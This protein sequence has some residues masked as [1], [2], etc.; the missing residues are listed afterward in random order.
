MGEK[1]K[2]QVLEVYID[3]GCFFYIVAHLGYH[4]FRI[5]QF[6]CNQDG[7]EQQNE[8]DKYRGANAENY[9][10][11]SIHRLF[12]SSSYMKLHQKGTE[13]L[14]RQRSAKVASAGRQAR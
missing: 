3:T 12:L 9:F 7:G 5:D 6:R 10:S 13:H 1:I 2:D 4:H 8:N 14:P 11:S